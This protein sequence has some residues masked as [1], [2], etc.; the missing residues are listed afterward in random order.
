[1]AFTKLGSSGAVASGYNTTGVK[2]IAL[3]AA[4]DLVAGNTYYAAF[5]S[6][7]AFGSNAPNL[8]GATVSGQTAALFGATAG[9]ATAFFHNAGGTL[10]SSLTVASVASV[11][12]MALREA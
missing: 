12:I 10:P 1:L 6:P 11:P 5:A 9:L 7:A 4:V 3:T 2:N 8:A